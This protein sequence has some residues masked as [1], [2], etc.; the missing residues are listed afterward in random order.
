MK[1]L[2]SIFFTFSII[3]NVVA[4]N[5]NDKITIA[6]NAKTDKL[7]IK[8][9]SNY[10]RNLKANVVIIDEE[11]EQVRSFKCNI[12][13]GSNTI[14]MQ[15]ALDLKEGIYTVE[16]TVKNKKSSTKLVLFK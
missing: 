7:E 5:I 3:V 12:I 6:S 10:K 13:K 16:L 11:G 4:G 14:C 8:Y 9:K 1:Y 2:L 15:D